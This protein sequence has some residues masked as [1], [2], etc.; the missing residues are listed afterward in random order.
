MS[1][2]TAPDLDSQG[3]DRNDYARCKMCGASA[4]DKKLS[5][6]PSR[7]QLLFGGFRARME[8]RCE[9]CE[10]KVCEWVDSLLNSP[11]LKGGK[12]RA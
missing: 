8:H 10:K 9:D 11:S 7:S 12:L 6:E 1:R 5:L 4:L 3:R 2:N